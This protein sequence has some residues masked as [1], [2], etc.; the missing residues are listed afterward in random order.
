MQK[1]AALTSKYFPSGSVDESRGSLTQKSGLGANTIYGKNSE[2]NN[3]HDFIRLFDDYLRQKFFHKFTM[4]VKRYA[5][6]NLPPQVHSGV[7]HRF[8]TRS[9]KLSIY[10]SSHFNSQVEKH[11]LIYLIED[12]K[13]VCEEMI[14]VYDDKDYWNSLLRDF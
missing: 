6:S 1:G 7:K 13:R 4:K 5:S 8:S 12:T 10:A 9:P 3:Q 14:E 11:D 2:A